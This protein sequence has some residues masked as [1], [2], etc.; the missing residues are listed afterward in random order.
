LCQTKSRSK[1]WS[2]EWGE[3]A[4]ESWAC[5]Q[6]RWLWRCILIVLKPKD[7]FFAMQ[8]MFAMWF[9]FSRN[10]LSSSSRPIGPWMDG[11]TS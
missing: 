2:A 3:E 4:K 8:M 1:T 7:Y 11:R 5:F 9:K 6:L 10:K